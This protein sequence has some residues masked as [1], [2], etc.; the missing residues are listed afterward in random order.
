MTKY[1]RKTA[2]IS[3]VSINL[4][5][6]LHHPHHEASKRTKTVL[7]SSAARALA[8]ARTLSALGGV[9]ASA[10]AAVKTAAKVT[11]KNPVR[12]PGLYRGPRRQTRTMHHRNLAR[13]GERVRFEKV[14]KRHG[15]GDAARMTGRGRDHALSSAAMRRTH[16]GKSSLNSSTPKRQTCHPR[17]L[18]LKVKNRPLRVLTPTPK[19]KRLGCSS[20]CDI[21]PGENDSPAAEHYPLATELNINDAAP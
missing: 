11:R 6:L 14:A 4:S 10:A 13:P 1:F 2:L 3:A 7:C 8:L 9:W 20:T 15:S 12:M 18:Q 21:A 17:L 5:S 19:V 16:R